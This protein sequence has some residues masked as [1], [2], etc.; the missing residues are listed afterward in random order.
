MLIAEIVND[1]NKKIT[2]AIKVLSFFILFSGNA[3]AAVA[4]P[5]GKRGQNFV[6]FA[7]VFNS[8]AQFALVYFLYI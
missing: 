6:I 4:V 5:L 8:R 2:W 1:G 7:L 3:K